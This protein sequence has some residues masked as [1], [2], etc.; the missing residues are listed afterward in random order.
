[1]QT[2][3]FIVTIT[4][5]LILVCA[6]YLSFSFVTNH[7]ESEAQRIALKKA[8]I[9]SPDTSNDKYRNAYNEYISGIEKKKV[10]L[11]YTYQEVREKQLGLGLDLKGGMNVTLQIS[12]PDILRA[13][14]GDNKDPKFNK[15]IET[16][17]SQAQQEDFVGAF[18]KEYKRIAPE[19]NLA[20]VFRSMEKVKDKPDATDAQVEAFLKEEVDG[21]P[22]KSSA[23]VSTNSESWPRTSKNFKAPAAFCSNSRALRSL[24][25]CANC[26]RE[27][28]T[29]SSTPPIPAIAA[30]RTR[31]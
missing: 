23:R 2:K 11:G 18:C 14:S 12:V 20:Q 30:T 15:A 13:L 29:W 6:F 24:S 7:Y 28:Q 25:A 22:T 16:I 27:P 31:A 4:A 5:A 21:T 26:F 17:A 8:G 3:G 9:K 19:G 10:Y 1:M